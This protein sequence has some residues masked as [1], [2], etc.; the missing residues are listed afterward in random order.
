MVIF[1]DDVHWIDPGSDEFLAE[2]VEAVSGTRTFLLLNFRPEYH[3]DWGTKS[4][5]QQMPLTPLGPE[6]IRE[7]LQDLLG[8]DASVAD[9]PELV[10]ERTG[11]NPFFIE[12][13]VQGLVESG[14]LEGTRGHYRLTR[15][16][17]DLAIPATVQAVLAARIDRLPEREK[18][19]LQDAAVIGRKFP[20]SILRHVAE[21]PDSDLA[22]SLSALQSA[23]FILE[24]ALYPEAEYAFKHPLTQ[25]VSLESQLSDRRAR[26][27]AAV[28][29]AIEELHKDK[30]DEEA[31]LIAHHWEEAGEASDA[32]RWHKRAAVWSGHTDPDAASR[33]W[34][35]ICDLLGPEPESEEGRILALEA[36][37]GVVDLGWRV[38]LERAV[39]DR[40]VSEGR[41]LARAGDEES[42][43]RLLYGEFTI[44]VFQGDANGVVERATEACDLV[45]RVDNLALRMGVFQRRG[46]ACL[47]EGR[48]DDLMRHCGEIIAQDPGVPGFGREEVGF[49]PY[50]AAG[51]VRAQ[52]LVH[53]G[54]FAEAAEALEELSRQARSQGED[55]VIVWL[56]EALTVR[57]R[58]FGDTEGLVERL[59]LGVDAAR[60]IGT[61][62]FLGASLS[63]LGLGHVLNGSWDEGIRALESGLAILRQTQTYLMWA[64]GILSD[65]AIA[66]LG[67]GEG[68]AARA[69]ADEAVR[70]SRE[71][72]I[73]VLQPSTLLVRAHVSNALD[74][75][76]SR[77]EHDL[78]EGLE[79][80]KSIG[81]RAW[82]PLFHEERA[83]L[84]RRL[85]DTTTYESELAHAHRL[86]VEN[87]A[88]PHAER[89]AR[90]LA[91]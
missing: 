49:N 26:T 66:R 82:E 67:R 29:R 75:P 36:R 83:R 43:A 38:G 52:G 73:V 12:E 23:E 47:T 78:R 13:I 27:H 5:Y 58:L 90:E 72:N 80:V 32:S 81:A 25:Q 10:R 48:F 6:A 68:D 62:S 2:T 69:A 35:R 30:L 70:R 74:G 28:A 85:G 37:A 15:P 20:E 22:T 31:A 57:A 63:F 53:L 56:G 61:R 86:F 14:S 77:V 44:R 91:S 46:W 64:P 4:Y 65:L 87:G 3:A 51:F 50:V 71:G 39:L 34:L 16:V 1:L 9:L 84:A 76:R 11:G 55:E 41:A 7:L 60:R 24:E 40:L 19:V 21:L 17:R 88:T 33:H 59:S 42:L 54:R 89:I 18:R 79:V 45:D 8:K